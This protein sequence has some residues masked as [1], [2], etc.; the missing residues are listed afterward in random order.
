M[1]SPGQ[2]ILRTNG[3]DGEAFDGNVDDLHIATANADT[4]YNFDPDAV[5]A[6]TPSVTTDAA[7]GISD[8]DATLNGTNGPVSAQEES[9]WVSTST[10]DTSSPNIPAG[11]YSTP[12]LSGVGAGA[13]FSDP[14]SLVT[15]NGI[16]TGGAS[17]NMPAITPNTTYYYVAWANV[18]GTWYPGAVQ[19]FTT[20]S[21]ADTEAPVVTVTPDST[22][23]LH[24]SET[25]TITVS[26]NKP[27]DPS[28]NTHVWV[29]LY[30]NLPPQAGKGATLDLSSGTATF[31]VDTTQLANGTSTL[32][33]GRVEDAAGNWSGTGDNYFGNYVIQNY[34]YDAADSRFTANP[35][36]VRAN[37][38][39]DTAAIALVPAQATAARYTY[40]QTDGSNVYAN[41]PGTEHIQAGQFPVPSTGQHQYRGG[42]SAAEG[43]YTVT[44]EYEVGGTWYPITGSAT[45]YA[46]GLPTGDFIIPSASSS[47]FRPSDN[48][49]RVEAADAN[50]TFRD[51]VFNV[52]GTNYQVNRADCDLREAGHRV[53]CDVSS[54][55]NWAGLA[56]G[57][58]TATA[59]LYNLASNHAAITSQSF[60]VS[61]S[62]PTVTNFQV[63][64]GS[65]ASSSISVSADA[66][67]PTGIK[68][69]DFYITA[70]RAGD[71]VCDGN[72][73]KLADSD[74]TSGTGSTYTATLD[75]SALSGKYCVNVVAGNLAA[76]H[77]HPQSLAV[78]VDTTAPSVPT[79]GLP[80]GTATS[81]NDFYFTWDASTDDSG[82]P[83]TYLFQ[84]SQN[85]AE[86][87][88]VLTSG[89]W[90]SG[91][92]TG[93]TIHSTGAHDGTWYW[94]VRAQDAAGNWSA[95]SPIWSK[96]IDT[97]GP[98]QPAIT[99]P[100]DGSTLTT[101][102]WNDVT[103]TDVSDSGTPIT[104]V[105]Q[106]ATDPSTN[107]DGSFTNPAY[108][109][110]TLATT[111]QPTPGTAAGTYY[112][113]VK[114]TDAAGNS[115]W[116]DPIEVIVDNTSGAGHPTNT[117]P[118]AD[119]QS[120]SVG[121]NGTLG[122]VLTGSDADG[123]TLSFAT[124]S[125]PAHGT[126]TGSAPN[127]TYTPNTGFTGT[128][129]FTFTTNDG[130]LDSAPATVTVTVNAAD[131]SVPSGTFV[132]TPSAMQGWA[133][134]TATGAGT[135]FV[136]DDTS[137]NGVGALQ[138][139]TGADNES[140]AHMTSPSFNMP[141]ADVSSLSY[142]TK[143]VAVP[144][145]QK[146]VGN[147]TLRVMI[148]TTGDGVA[149]DELMYEPYYNGFDGTT[150]TG[151][152]TWAITPSS[153]KFWSNE[154]NSYNS[155]GGV[156]AGSYAS[157]FTLADVLHDYPNAHVVG[158]VLSMGTWNDSQTVEADNLQINGTTQYSF[159]PDAAPS[160]GN[161]GGSVQPLF[162]SR[163]SSGSGGSSGQT[164]NSGGGEVLGASTYNFTRDLH[165]G[166]TG[167]DVV[168]LQ[169][170]L[171]SSG[172]P[173]SAGATGYFGLQTQAALAKFQSDHGITPALG[174]FGPITRAL[175]NSGTIETTP[176]TQNQES[177]QQQ[178]NDLLAKL[179]A[180]RAQL[181]A[182]S[183]T[184]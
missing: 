168:A 12:V 165:L 101:A 160:N 23:V 17:G 155:L 67:D 138:L 90:T 129:S 106:S 82:D 166:S 68:D 110:G 162:F 159:E 32:D 148:D 60:T 121:E 108:T 42:V 107:P 64:P 175:V 85:P 114:A 137:P 37:N 27:L 76:T 87:G 8:S 22:T 145:A 55:S 130:A 139:S 123:D 77:S 97:T 70:P 74:Q 104:Y 62:V 65:V 16:V 178:I 11:V 61:D 93:P 33:V 172:Y 176:V 7:T 102:T 25:F 47:I 72:G 156:G 134:S 167:D 146:A 75:T 78:T 177:V 13:S 96:T 98:A 43:V 92:L 84:S 15:T 5:V 125:S 100:A 57:T 105:Y 128:D 124:T 111:S 126:L 20:T 174:Y 181:N 80:N 50:D 171:I 94:Q 69:V 95:W 153:G 169:Q 66:T 151:W 6:P 18:G 91:T 143:V 56:P 4:T 99:S 71:G 19:S 40:T 170:F 46:L 182:A 89:L 161:G 131:S 115:A 31:T 119:D 179:A 86:T 45:L 141:L 38:S 149:D 133:T 116:S 3:A 10:I 120:V 103:W 152:Q 14:L 83:V 144:D 173:I 81:T 122:I 29:Y 163:G 34:A 157:N 180:L 2:L 184:P 21:A 150:M 26:D 1:R 63:V 158:L 24:G 132:I 147:A 88:G 51:V 35:E 48:P 127:L 53:L 164:I 39:G 58:Y 59:T 44:G 140:V 41:V 52:D 183:T 135:D 118:V 79:N 36:Y 54:A 30:N 28:K 136:T 154:T 9:F 109:S 73:T 49:L 142:A 117:A 112:V 113:H